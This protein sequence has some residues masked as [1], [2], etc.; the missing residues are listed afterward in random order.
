LPF[1]D[2]LLLFFNNHIKRNDM[3][4][5]PTLL[6]GA[7]LTATAHAA[8]SEP[9]NSAWSLLENSNGKA[10]Y[11]TEDGKP[12]LVLGCNDAGKIS[13]T[14]SLDGNVVDKLQ[15]RSLRSRRVSGTL[16]VEGKEPAT[17]YWAYLP[18]RNMASP[19]ENKFAR[20][21]YNAAVTGSNV[22]LDLGRRG[23]YEFTPPKLN[24]DFETFA[25]GCA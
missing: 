1:F 25:S 20:R 3:K 8:D 19:M 21:L 17:L 12:A 10:I 16:T 4:I 14:F 7:A 6:L 18:T 15:S 13:A 2:K 24:S 23:T 11:S 22:T 9:S 5:I